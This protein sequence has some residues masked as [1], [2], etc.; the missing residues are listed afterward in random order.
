MNTNFIKKNFFFFKSKTPRIAN[1]A[2]YSSK[3]LKK[4]RFFSKIFEFFNLIRRV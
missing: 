1:N 4:T 3:I 2:A